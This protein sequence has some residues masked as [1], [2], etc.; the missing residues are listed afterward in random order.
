MPLSEDEQRILREIEQQ[1][2]A[3]DPNFA[4]GVGTTSLYRHGLRRLKLA[5]L[6]F[7]LGVAL[8]VWTLVIGNY[9]LA[10]VLG[11][12]PMFGAALLFESNVRKL[13]RA[14]IQ[15]VT[16]SVKAAGLRDAFGSA[17]KK[18]RERFRRDDEDQQ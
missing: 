16:A 6:L 1:F 14:G 9:V 3:T 18:A 17:G 15:Q 13:G 4:R 10:F 8:L 12:G 7:L 5:G 2:Y 11:A